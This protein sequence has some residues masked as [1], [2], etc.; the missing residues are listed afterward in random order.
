MAATCNYFAN[1][2]V[3]V[4]G[5]FLLFSFCALLTF[6]VAAKFFFIL[7]LK[8]IDFMAKIVEYFLPWTVLLFPIAAIMRH[9]VFIICF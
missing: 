9:V 6:A 8:Q 5:V 2:E 7:L 3:L 1:F 4:I